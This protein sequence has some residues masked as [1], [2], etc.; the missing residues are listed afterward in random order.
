MLAVAACKFAQRFLVACPLH[1]KAFYISSRYLSSRAPLNLFI[2]AV[3]EESDQ[4]GAAL[5]TA[6]KRLTGRDVKLYGVVSA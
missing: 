3:D 6:V 5:V 2:C 1:S 4:A